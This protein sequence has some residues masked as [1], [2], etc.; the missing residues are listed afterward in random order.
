MILWE[1][2]VE[3]GEPSFVDEA[4]NSARAGGTAELRGSRT[5]QSQLATVHRDG[6]RRSRFRST[7]S[8]ALNGVSG[9]A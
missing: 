7:A 3:R 5:G 6:S 2:P 9:I 1:R 4:R 8:S